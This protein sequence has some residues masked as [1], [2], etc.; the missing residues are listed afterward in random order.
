M[1]LKTFFFLTKDPTIKLER[2]PH[3]SLFG[4]G[5]CLQLGQE[6]ISDK[7]LHFLDDIIYEDEKA[8]LEQTL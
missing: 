7:L 8:C 5:Y 4:I 3:V 6:P 2:L 1:G